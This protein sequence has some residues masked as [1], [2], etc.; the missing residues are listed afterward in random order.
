MANLN[1]STQNATPS[2]GV[3]VATKRRTPLYLYLLK[4]RTFIAL[5][6]LVIVF[7][8]LSPNFLSAGQH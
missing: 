4:A 1:I 6:V 2:P 3:K 7:S 8:I 5:I